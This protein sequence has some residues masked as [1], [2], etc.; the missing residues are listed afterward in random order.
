MLI[1]VVLVI[2]G[3]FLIVSNPILGLIP[4]LLL[5]IAG[6]VVGAVLRPIQAVP[7]YCPPARHM[8]ERKRRWVICPPRRQ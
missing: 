5:I 2:G 3:I 4:G 8:S 7:G 1:V 6:A